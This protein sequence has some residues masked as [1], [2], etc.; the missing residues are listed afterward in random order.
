VNK[1]EFS[2]L[3]EGD[4][5]QEKSSGLAYVVVANYGDRVLVVRSME[6]S[7]P[8]EWWLVRKAVEQVNPIP[9]QSG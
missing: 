2:Q 8:D 7:N 9:P 1:T 6:L 3:Q 5:V 4:I